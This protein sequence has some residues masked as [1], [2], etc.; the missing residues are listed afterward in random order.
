MDHMNIVAKATED[1]FVAAKEFL[2]YH[3]NGEDCGMCGF[4]WVN[5]K[6]KHKGN[7]KLGKEERKILREMGFELDWTGKEFSW[8][9][10]S[11]LRVQNMDC[12]EVGARAAAKVLCEAGFDAYSM[13]RFD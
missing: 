6:P 8:W 11:G 5:I 7:T 2:N 13:S 12:K 3:M 4:A 1:A 10:P 9:N